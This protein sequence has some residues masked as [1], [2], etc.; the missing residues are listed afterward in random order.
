MTGRFTQEDVIYNDGLNLYAYCNSNPVMYCDPSGLALS[1]S[2]D[3]AYSLTMEAA[4]NPEL[5]EAAKRGDIETLKKYNALVDT[6][7]DFDGFVILKGNKPRDQKAIDLLNKN[8]LDGIYYKSGKPDFSPV[9]LFQTEI[10]NMGTER[11]KI[12]TY[13]EKSGKNYSQFKQGVATAIYNSKG[14][15]NELV[16]MN[17]I[18]ANQTK[19]TAQMT[20]EFLDDIRG[21]YSFKEI[22]EIQNIH[23]DLGQYIHKNKYTI[24]EAYNPLT[25]IL[26]E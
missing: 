26:M 11:G 2:E 19:Y 25:H 10:P 21:N 23:K 17:I 20:Q 12:G 24:H 7:G 18:P 22:D 9:S 3:R 15:Y 4:K 14:D 8:G 5:I 16:R 1:P 6:S 13:L